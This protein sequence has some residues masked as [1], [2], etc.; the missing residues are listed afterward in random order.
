MTAILLILVAVNE[1][2]HV[3]NLIKNDD[4]LRHLRFSPNN[5]TFVITRP[6]ARPH[7]HGY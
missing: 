3:E 4:L 5:K 2:K 6:D 7:H 1:L